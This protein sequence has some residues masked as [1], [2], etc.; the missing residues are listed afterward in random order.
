M[1]TRKIFALGLLTLLLLSVVGVTAFA[2]NK[3]TTDVFTYYEYNAET[4]KEEM[5]TLDPQA[6]LTRSVSQFDE[7]IKYDVEGNVISR[8]TPAQSGN[9]QTSSTAAVQPTARNPYSSG[10]TKLDPTSG[11]NKTI[12]YVYVYLGEH[13]G[14]KMYDYGTAFLEGENLLVTAGHLCYDSMEDDYELGWTEDLYFYPG[15]YTDLEGEHHHPYGS[16]R[17]QGI[18]VASAWKNDNNN[19]YDW[20]VVTLQTPI[21]ETVGNLGK[22]WQSASYVGT[23]V[24]TIG[25]PMLLGLNNYYFMYKSTGTV[26]S[27]TSYILTC[28]YNTYDRASG[29]PILLNNSSV[30]IGIQSGADNSNSYAVRITE[31]LYDLLQ[32]KLS[33]YHASL[34]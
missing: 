24:T 13:E 28:N 34:E 33:E 20:G 31:Y 14:T 1:K 7:E 2:D 21:G 32:E 3:D 22:R 18:I 15:G 29:A 26:T 16:A 11:M 5:F 9:L 6:T 25:Y 23:N 10:Y 17:R 8:T 27:N 4:G 19:N 30:V 12:G